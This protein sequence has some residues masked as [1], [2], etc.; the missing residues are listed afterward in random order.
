MTTTI[1][2]SKETKEMLRKLGEKGESYDTI[3]RSLIE[4][5]GWERLD[6]RWNR[7]LEKDEFIP[8]DEL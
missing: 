4:E 8:F 5:I 1:A 2:V 7:I 3:I 6:E